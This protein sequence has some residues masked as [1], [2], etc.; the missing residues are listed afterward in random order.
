MARPLFQLGPRLAL[1]AQLIRGG[2][3]LCDVGTDHAYLPIW[4]VKSGRVPQA[5][6]SDCNPGPLEAAAGNAARYGAADKLTLRLSDG[7]R[8][9]PP[10]EAEDI[11][12]AGMGGE[13]ILRI[14]GETPWLRDPD[15]RLV[16][17]P[18]SSA[19]ELRTGL[20]ELGFELLEEQ[21]VED[22]GKVYTAFS[23]QYIG[24]PSEADRLYSYMGK[25]RPG[26]EA[27]RK[28]AEKVVRDLRGRLEG[29]LRG[30][31]ADSP[32]EL[33]AVMEEVGAQ[34]LKQR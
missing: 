26:P 15:R 33:R 13:L 17:Q 30:Q 24:K 4:L 29:A 34:Y 18:M 5:T 1:C 32:E 21:A 16:L 22:A 19:R 2:R 27:V 9:I 7:L 20:R 25:L 3:P 23:A 10:S 12:I 28:Y 14:V 6:A 11:V 31:G 8:E